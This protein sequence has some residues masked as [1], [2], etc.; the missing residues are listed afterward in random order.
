[1]GRAS[2]PATRWR[3]SWCTRHSTKSATASVS[4][5]REPVR[6]AGEIE[7]HQR[8]V[9]GDGGRAVGDVGQGPVLP[10]G[11]EAQQQRLQL[12]GVGAVQLARGL[13]VAQRVDEQLLAGP[14][15][16]V[17]AAAVD[18]RD[19][20]AQQRL[21]V[22]VQGA[23]ESVGVVGVADEQRVQRQQELA[24]LV[25]DAREV[26]DVPGAD[27]VPVRGARAGRGARRG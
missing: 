17:G 5:G 13:A 20:V 11:A 21:L 24:L 2:S 15:A 10:V 6:Q 22:G 16:A 3:R 19:G 1:M 7:Q 25:G 27:D 8:R 14:L 26:G 4:A 23:H 9:V 18:V 12:V